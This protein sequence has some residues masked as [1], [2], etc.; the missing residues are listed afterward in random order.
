[1]LA[2][3]LHCVVRGDAAESAQAVLQPMLASILR[4][5]DQEVVPSSCQR[6][7]CSS[8][9]WVSARDPEPR[10][11]KERSR[12]GAKPTLKLPSTR[13]EGPLPSGATAV[14]SATRAALTT[15][16][17]KTS[18]LR[19]TAATAVGR[20]GASVETPLTSSREIEAPAPSDPS[21]ERSKR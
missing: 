5:N 3:A 4:V 17:P 14:S 7:F 11:W 21:V 15:L 19:V 2:K 6:L 16:R 8:V 12:S 1:M 9:F 20:T 10:T 13:E 18:S